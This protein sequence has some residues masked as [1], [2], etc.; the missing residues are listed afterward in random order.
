MALLLR[1]AVRPAAELPW[2]PAVLP[3]AVPESPG[4]AAVTCRR[5]VGTAAASAL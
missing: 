2:V 5:A 3:V 4:A 1:R